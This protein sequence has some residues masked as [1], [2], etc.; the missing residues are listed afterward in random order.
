M[1][2]KN[3]YLV[4]WLATYRFSARRKKRGDGKKKGEKGEK[5][6]TTIRGR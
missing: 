1:Y 4:K 3:Q 2:E 5:I 6:D